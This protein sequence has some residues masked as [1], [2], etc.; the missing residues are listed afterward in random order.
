ME[1]AGH[2]R[3]EKAPRSRRRGGAAGEEGGGGGRGNL[4]SWQRTE[5]TGSRNWH[6]IFI[7]SPAVILS[8]V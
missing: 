1:K 7:S 2:G 4:L 5:Q 6:N 3:K 8:L